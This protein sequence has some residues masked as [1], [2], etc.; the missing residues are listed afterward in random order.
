[1]PGQG[2]AIG[3]H[4]VC[5]P[6]QRGIP[7][8]GST[9]AAD[10]RYV[11]FIG[12]LQECTFRSQG[13]DGIDDKVCFWVKHQIERFLLYEERQ[14]LHFAIWIDRQHPGLCHFG[15]P[16]SQRVIGGQD[17][18][19]EVCYAHR[20]EIDQAYVPYA[21]SNQGFQARTAYCPQ[22]HDCYCFL[23]QRLDDI[24]TEESCYP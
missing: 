16:H 9:H 13:I 2:T 11:P 18:S 10:N 7:S 5:S 1:M 6:D 8:Q 19:V 22:S 23:V 15:F 20:I 21:A 14:D 3:I 24:L 12:S 17:L 4:E